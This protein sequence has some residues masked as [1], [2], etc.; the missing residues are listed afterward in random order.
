VSGIAKLSGL[1]FVLAAC[2]AGSLPAS[3]IED[4]SIYLHPGVRVP[5]AD[6]VTLDLHCTGSG[7]PAVVFD[8]GHQD[9]APAWSTVQPR[10]AQWT[11]TCS[12]DRAGSGF[13]SAGPM[14]RTST[15]IADELHD[16]LHNAGIRGPYILVGH[17]F[18]GVNMRTFAYRHMPEVAGL[19]LIDTDAGDVALPDALQRE[20]AVFVE[21]ERDLKACRDALAAGEPLA[22]VPVPALT[23]STCEQRFFRG[24]P[25]K[26][27]SP[28]LNAQL[29]KT[30]ATS[31]ALFDEVVSELHEMPGDEVYLK[32]HQ[33]S[34]GSRPIRVLT[35]ANHYDDTEQTP[36]A[37]PITAATLTF[38]SISPKLCSQRSARS[39]TPAARRRRSAAVTSE[40][41]RGRRS[42]R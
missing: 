4:D 7:T 23:H 26:A 10:V 17:A 21:Q 22:S 5:A 30:A 35:A 36:A 29:L 40:R 1:F 32:Q 9:W 37:T 2:C 8:S 41:R 33:Q 20:H 39:T 13:S 27:W 15:R 12:Y 28:E 38:S 19:V 25:E 31:V 34:L 3:A 16:A 14:P 11:R 18:G 24:F 6:G 42:D